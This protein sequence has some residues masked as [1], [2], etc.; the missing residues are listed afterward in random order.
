VN[1]EG[2]LGK[3]APQLKESM[4]CFIVDSGQLLALCDFDNRSGGGRFECKGADF[5]HCSSDQTRRFV[6]VDS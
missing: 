4:A 1:R 2:K 6:E 3:N 5:G